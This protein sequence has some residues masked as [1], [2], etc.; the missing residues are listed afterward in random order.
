MLFWESW[1]WDLTLSLSPGVAVE[2]PEMSLPNALS[3]VSVVM[4]LVLLSKSSASGTSLFYIV[5]D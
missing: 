5:L 1:F 3:T 4:V 2:L